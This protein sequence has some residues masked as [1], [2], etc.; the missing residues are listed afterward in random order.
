M[1]RCLRYCGVC[2]E[3]CKCVP[4]GTYGNKDECPCYR[5]DLNE[6]SFFSSGGDVVVRETISNSIEL[7][8]PLEH[9]MHIASPALTIS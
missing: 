5:D 2:F 9:C 6:V 3:E 1:D 7:L 4:S 8:L